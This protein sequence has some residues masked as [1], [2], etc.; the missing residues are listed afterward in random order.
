MRLHDITVEEADGGGLVRLSAEITYETRDLPADRMWFDVPGDLA[1]AVSRNA[2]PWLVALA[3]IA[4]TLGERLTIDAPADPVLVANVRELLRIWTS[5]YPDLEAI[6]IVTAGAPDSIEPRQGRTAAFFSGGVD[7]FF[8]ALRHRLGDGT[9]HSVKIDDLM[10]IH[11]FDIP[12][13]HQEAFDRLRRRLEPVAHDLDCR[14]VVVST[15]LRDTRFALGDWQHLT[16]GAALAAVGLTL[17]SRYGQLLIPSSAGYRDLR[18]WGSHPLTDPLFSSSRMRVVHDGPAFM[19]AEKTEYV[20]RSNLA[21]EHLRVCWKNGTDENCSRCNN[22]LR[23]MLTLEALGVLRRCPTFDAG[24]LDLG[25]AARI[26]CPNTWDK[27]QFGYV[28]DLATRCGRHD[29]ARAVSASLHGSVRLDSRLALV[30]R[31]GQRA[32]LWR[33]APWLRR[34]LLAGWIL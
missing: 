24:A 33:A 20:S 23:T 13:R 29:I 19:R 34:R 8:T 21:L 3:P 7:S 31:M 11:G 30:E 14:L 28:R 26:Y 6:D 1:E 10:L 25:T 5:W 2:N 17:E 16:H 4:A 12:L 18:F 32:G 27:R 22:C 15:N 9:P